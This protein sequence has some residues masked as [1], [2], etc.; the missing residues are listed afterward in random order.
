M[1]TFGRM[2]VVF[3]LV[4]VVLQEGFVP[5]GLCHIF[6]DLPLIPTTLMHFVV[7]FATCFTP[8]ALPNV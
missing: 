7:Q 8:I 6:I 5:Q 4:F 1:H 3:L 2:S